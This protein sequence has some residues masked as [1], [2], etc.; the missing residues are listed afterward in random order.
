MPVSLRHHDSNQPRAGSSHARPATV[1]QS[2]ARQVRVRPW[3]VGLVFVLSVAGVRAQAT[4]PLQ[5]HY[6]ER[7]PYTAT[8]ASGE[9]VGLLIEPLKR[10]L[11]RNRIAHAWV[12]TPSQRQLVLVQQGQGPDC[13]IGWFR[14]PE[15]ETR[16][17]FSA[18]LYQDRP[19][20][21]LVKADAS[22]PPYPELAQRLRDST[23]PLLTKEG[24]SYGPL[25]DDLIRQHPQHVVRTTAESTQM[26]RMIDAGRA[27]WMIMA[28]EEADALFASIGDAARALRFVPLPGAPPG[29]ARHLYCNRS[30]PAEVLEQLDR[31]LLER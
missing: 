9:P 20:M 7:P 1:R 21:A 17:R 8:G 11:Q 19:F 24:Y 14:N 12:R 31:V 22:A 5:L 25:I 3:W 28:P 29:Q 30:V 16:G 27:G 4:A 18:P 10:A 26:A 2:V 6:Q 13:G 23:L 15:R